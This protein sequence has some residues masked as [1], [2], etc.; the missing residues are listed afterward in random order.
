MDQSMSKHGTPTFLCKLICSV[1]FNPRPRAH[2]GVG[3]PRGTRPHP[4]RSPG[5]FIRYLLFGLTQKE[6]EGL[7]RTEDFWTTGNGYFKEQ[8]TQPQTLGYGLADSPAGLLAWIYEKL[9]RWT[10]EYP[11]TD[12]EGEGP[13]NIQIRHVILMNESSNTVLTWISIYWFSRAGPA[14][15]VRIYFEFA[16][17]NP[18]PTAAESPVTKAITGYS[19]FPKEVI[20][21]PRRS[22]SFREI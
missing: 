17:A 4:I 14:A 2:P 7:Q 11:W 19:Y 22:G 8:A 6:E 1:C 20:S 9:Y 16:K 21:L 15:S 3:T 5:L 18:N 10:D 12:D 13:S